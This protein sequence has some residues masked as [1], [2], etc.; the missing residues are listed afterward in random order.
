M[1]IV[2]PYNETTEKTI[3][4]MALLYEKCQP[5]ILSSLFEDHF[6]V[7]VHKLI[8]SAIRNLYEAQKAIDIASVSEELLNLGKLDEAG[9]VSFLS[10]LCEGVLIAENLDFHVK[11]LQDKA[12]L[13]SLLMMMDEKITNWEESKISDVGEYLADVERDIL[14]ITKERR[15]EGFEKADTILER[16]RDK[17]IKEAKNFSKITGTPSGFIDLDNY[18]NGFQSGDLIILAA[19]PGMGKTALALNFAVNSIDKKNGNGTVAIFSVEMPKEQLMKRILCSQCRISSDELKRNLG[20]ER[21]SQKIQAVINKLS[22]MNLYIDDSSVIKLSDIQA[23]A[24]RLKKIHDDLHLIIVDYIG[25]I[26]PNQAS[27]GDNRQQEIAEISRGLKSLARELNCPIICLSQ[28]SRLVERRPDKHPMLSDLRESGAIEQDADIVLFIYREDYYQNE[29]DKE[30][31]NVENPVAE[32]AIA[33]HR[34]GQT[35]GVQLLFVKE[36]G[37]FDNLAEDKKI[38]EYAKD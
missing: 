28:L 31:N 9:G 17:V 34:N 21:K 4:G 13:R 19:R 23:K 36:H 11:V 37:Y 6:F 8:Y 12:L 18:T 26:A 5:I 30:K 15:A 1:A 22:E 7:P 35:G 27:K 10:N 33:K 24:R 25:L 20:D 38:K 16:V 29:K 3:L 2:L 14:S 32:I